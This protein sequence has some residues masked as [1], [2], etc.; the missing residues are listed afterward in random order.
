MQDNELDEL[1]RAKLGSLE[2]QPSARAWDKIEAGL[3]HEKKRSWVPVLSMAATILVVLATGTWFILDKPAKVKQ[4]Q[5][6]QVPV[7]T[8][9]TRA[10]KVT[11]KAV[12]ETVLEYAAEPVITPNHMEPVNRIAQQKAAKHVQ[13]AVS[14]KAVNVAENRELPQ[15]TDNHE[16]LLAAVQPE[17]AVMHPVVPEI[18]LATHIIDNNAPV[19]KT[20][21]AVKPANVMASQPE[22]KKKRGIHSLGDLINVVVAKVDK[23][24]DKIIEFTSTD[25][26]ESS[27]TGINLG[28]FKVK[29]DK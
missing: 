20:D 26:D 18:Q 23:R 8:Q 28:L 25:E 24:E 9:S 1:F 17:K 10:I 2:V 21:N 11:P 29:K 19:V 27:V 22:K 7:K 6:A 14:I 12:E 5:V 13:P 16:P 4:N 3:G 15:S